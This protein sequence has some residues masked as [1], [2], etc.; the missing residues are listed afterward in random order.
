MEFRYKRLRQVFW[1]GLTA[2]LLL[3]FS[4]L[5]VGLKLLSLA[6]LSDGIFSLLG[7]IS[8][9]LGLIALYAAPPD[10]SP[11][12]ARRRRKFEIMTP[13]LLAGPLFICGWEI[14]GSCF[15]RLLHPVSRPVFSWWGIAF[16]LGTIGIQYALAA[17]KKE[18]A[19]VLNSRLLA[20]YAS[21]GHT[22]FLSAGAALTGLTASAV[23]WHRFDACAAI[24]I[25]LLTCT[26][27]YTLL[28]RTIENSTSGQ[29][30]NS[31]TPEKPDAD[32]RLL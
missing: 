6:V 31:T 14:L 4:K 8:S 16:F 11:L 20:A 29:P 9:G 17:Y 21:G 2:S 3:F 32:R 22:A 28:D 18:R 15:E 25:V 7:G 24:F 1:V 30:D 13:V 10:L 12:Q 27:S 19:L 26:G 5:L 23:G